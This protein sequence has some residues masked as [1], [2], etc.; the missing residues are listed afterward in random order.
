MRPKRAHFKIREGDRVRSIASSFLP[1]VSSYPA[2]TL[3]A[4]GFFQNRFD[5]DFEPAVQSLNMGFSLT[6]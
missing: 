5:T 3:C 1:P 4:P 2:C 6:P